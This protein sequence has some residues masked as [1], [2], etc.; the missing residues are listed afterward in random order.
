VNPPIPQ[1]IAKIEVKVNSPS[2]YE[3]YAHLA[4]FYSNLALFCVNRISGKAML[5][6]L[7]T[8]FS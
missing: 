3:G 6:N 8:Y 5:G 1:G 7:L 2:N 4:W